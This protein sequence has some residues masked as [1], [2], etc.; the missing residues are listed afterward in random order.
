MPGYNCYEVLAKIL[1]HTLDVALGVDEMKKLGTRHPRL[2]DS[3]LVI[4]AELWSWGLQDED[5]FRGSF[6]FVPQLCHEVLFTM[7]GEE[8]WGDRPGVTTSE[9]YK[10]FYPEF[11]NLRKVV[12]REDGVDLDRAKKFCIALNLV[13][14]AQWSSGRHNL[15][16]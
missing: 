7:Y 3:V 2:D 13:G 10:A 4:T 14:I 6:V 8:V 12:I 16:A 11:E 1:D 15:V 5:A 9:V